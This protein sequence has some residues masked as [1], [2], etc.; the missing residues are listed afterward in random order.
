MGRALDKSDALNEGLGEALE[1]GA[2]ARDAHTAE[3]VCG[4]KITGYLNIKG[5]LDYARQ[6]EKKEM[7]RFRGVFRAI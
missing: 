2:E 6:Q 4:A 5:V 3:L 1:E 7:E